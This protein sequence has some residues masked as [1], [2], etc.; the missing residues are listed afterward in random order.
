MFFVF[1]SL[2]MFCADA[3]SASFVATHKSTGRRIRRCDF[4]AIVTEVSV[5]PSDSFASV[6]PVQG[7]IR[8]KSHIFF[9]PI[10]SVCTEV[11]S[12]YF[13]CYSSQVLTISS[14]LPNT[15][16]LLSRRYLTFIGV[17]CSHE[18]TPASAFVQRLVK[19]CKRNRTC[20]ANGCFCHL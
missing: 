3:P 5:T 9:G 13:S 16:Y 2:P 1:I 6:L 18:S 12:T 15:K 11:W 20:I 7:A 19:R 14:A 17:P 10:G 8:S 4:A